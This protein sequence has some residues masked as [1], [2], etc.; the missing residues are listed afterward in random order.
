[1]NRDLLFER[2]QRGGIYD[3]EHEV[4]MECESL[5]ARR[6]QI[7]LRLTITSC[8]RVQRHLIV[9]KPFSL[10]FRR[11]QTQLIVTWLLF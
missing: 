1:M 9:K 5:K 11:E 6:L 8:K 4:F 10:S 3:H 7:V 2:V